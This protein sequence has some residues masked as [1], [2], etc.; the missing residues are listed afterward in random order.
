MKKTLNSLPF[1]AVA[2]AS[3]IFAEEMDSKETKEAPK[4]MAAEEKPSEEMASEEKSEEAPTMTILDTALNNED[5]SILATAVKAA[6]LVDALNAEGPITVFAPTNEAFEKLPEGTL[7]MLL[8]P[9]NK[10][11]LVKIL[12][13]HAVGGKVMA[14]D[15]TT[16][17][18]ETLNGDSVSVV[19]TDGKPTIGGAEVL[20]ADVSASNGVVHVIDTVLLPE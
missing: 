15:L 3:P 1:V 16:T 6:G 5:L 13:F 2:F 7:E 12:K 8:E 18:V 19:V 9:E 17:E 4:E 20:N 11:K 14:A 10:E